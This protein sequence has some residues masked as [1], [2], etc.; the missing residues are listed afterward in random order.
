MQQRIEEYNYW[1]GF[2]YLHAFCQSEGVEHVQLS[3]TLEQFF[4]D[5][6]QDMSPATLGRI[7]C[8]LELPFT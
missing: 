6:K 1:L 7:S 4:I 3:D 5:Y 8:L 2:F